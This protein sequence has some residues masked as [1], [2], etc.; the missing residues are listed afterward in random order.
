[1]VPI[2]QAVEDLGDLVPE[3]RLESGYRQA[4]EGTVFGEADLWRLPAEALGN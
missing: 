2:G 1:M 3:E 4:V